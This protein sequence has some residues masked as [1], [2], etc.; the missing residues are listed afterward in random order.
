MVDPTYVIANPGSLAGG[1]T[2][3]IPGTGMAFSDNGAGTVTAN[4]TLI[5]GTIEQ[6]LRI[7]TAVNGSYTWTYPVPYD[8]GVVPVIEVVAEGPNPA[9]GTV[10]NAQLVGPPTN[11]GCT[12]Q[13]TRSTTTIQVLGINV[14]SLAAATATFVHIT[15]RA[16]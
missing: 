11:T 10:V 13:V 1:F 4:C 16:P 8:A 5:P 15:A 14:L 7:Q 2:Q 12:I 3:F 6:E 9:G